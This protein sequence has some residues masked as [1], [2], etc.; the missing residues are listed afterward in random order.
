L[1][2]RFKILTSLAGV[3]F[4]GM[5]LIIFVMSYLYQQHVIPTVSQKGLLIS[6]LIFASR[7]RARQDRP[8]NEKEALKRANQI[9]GMLKGEG[10]LGVYIISVAHEEIFSY[11][12]DPAL[13]EKL[14]QIASQCLEGT[15]AQVISSASWWRGMWRNSDTFISTHRV[16]TGGKKVAGASFA[17]SLEPE[18]ER[19]R[20]VQKI[21]FLYL[22]VNTVLFTGIGFSPLYRFT[23]KPLKKLTERTSQYR[24]GDGL[25]LA[26]KGSGNEWDS[27][28]RGV[29]RIVA[30]NAEDNQ[31]LKDTVQSL[32][33]ALRD[34]EAAQQ[35]IIRAEKLATVGRLASGLAH[36]I[37]NPIG[38]ILGY[39]ELLKAGKLPE[40]E[41]TD[42]LRRVEDELRRVDRIIRQM[43]DFSRPKTREGG[44][45][46]IHEILSGLIEM[47]KMQPLFSGIAM[48]V[49]LAADEDEVS[50]DPDQVRQ[51]FLNI[52]INAV[53][54]I[55]AERTG[56]RGR[57]S[58]SSENWVED[59]K[60]GAERRMIQLSF[61]DNGEGMSRECMEK[62]FDPF[63]T[64]K[65][66][67]KGCGLGLWVSTMI[68]EGLGGRMSV[69]SQDGI[70]TT[71]SIRL[72]IRG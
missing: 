20:K 57:L 31:K 13:L 71:M 50:A 54:A 24:F 41:V 12:D 25:L 70:G 38:I 56:R 10:C 5:L 37:G 23:I 47:M 16:M 8:T 64:T 52:I 61:T 1:G 72:P 4:I 63:F 29:N 66:P 68:I 58:I 18:I 34:L 40:D 21:A 3:L 32:Q 2:L 30:L 35:E 19:I 28:Y 7:E 42:I 51:A 17:F 6:N 33:S 43:L 53:D 22:I 49:D 15:G 27:L 9:V 45:A 11:A 62:I 55:E 36:E 44:S 67:Q 59:T 26:F 48:H 39:V 69:E 65:S 60:A 46:A 14:K